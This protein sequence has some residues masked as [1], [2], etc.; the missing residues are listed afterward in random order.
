MK[1]KININQDQLAAFCCRWMVTEFALFGSVLRSDFGAESDVDVLLS[2]KPE[3][4]WSL[5]DLNHMHDELCDLFGRE[6]DVLTRRS[7]ERSD[8]PIRRQNILSTAEI[9]HAA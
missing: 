5:F 1:A 2:F 9:I 7:V 6:V 8:N 4:K 3:A